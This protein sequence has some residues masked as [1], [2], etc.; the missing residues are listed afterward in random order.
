MSNS[1]QALLLKKKIQINGLSSVSS[2][3]H[4]TNITVRQQAAS[5]AQG[6][7]SNR[8]GTILTFHFPISALFW[9]V[10]CCLYLQ[11]I[12]P[13]ALGIAAVYMTVNKFNY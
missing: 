4:Q 9:Q 11:N 8:M 3:S 6:L 7:L 12:T 5:Q 2:S 1:L 10:F 13:H